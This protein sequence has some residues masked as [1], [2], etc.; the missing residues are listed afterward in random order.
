MRKMAFEVTKAMQEAAAAAIGPKPLQLHSLATPNGIKVAIFL[1][2]L[3]I[4]YEATTIDI[5]TGVQKKEPFVTICPNGRIPALVDPN[6]EGGDLNIMESGAILMYLAEKTGQFLPKDARKKSQTIQWLM[7]QMGGV[8]PMFGQMGHF[9]KYA[10]KMGHEIEYAQQ[11]YLNETIRLVGVLDK[12]LEGKDWVIGDEYTIAD[13]SIMPWIGCIDRGY[14]LWDKVFGGEV[15]K[16]TKFPNVVRWYN[17]MG[18][19]AAVLKARDITPFPKAPEATPE[20]MAALF[21]QGGEDVK[22]D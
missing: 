14:G 8:G 15:G 2:E 4:P 12:Q 16:E 19:R 10:P 11:R 17:S 20:Q 9:W 7:W 3:Q 6:A 21:K 13:M 5:R 1:E 18:A 22:K